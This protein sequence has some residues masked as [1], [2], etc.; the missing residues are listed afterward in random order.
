MPKDTSKN[1]ES[2]AY[3]QYYVGSTTP[4]PASVQENI[5]NDPYLRASWK[6]HYAADQARKR[7]EDLQSWS[8]CLPRELMDIIIA[9]P[10]LG[11]REHLALAGEFDLAAKCILGTDQ[12]LSRRS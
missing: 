3:M 8:L 10:S 9:D 6:R 4:V 2:E 5:R 7:A 11:V 1:S 12:L